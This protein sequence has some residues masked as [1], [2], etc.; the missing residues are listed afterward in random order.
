MRM[1]RRMAIAG[2][3]GELIYMGMDA[4]N[5]A[6]ATE[7]GYTYIL[8][9]NP[10]NATGKVTSIQMYVDSWQS[11]NTVTVATVYEVNTDTFTTRDWEYVYP[12][13]SGLNTLT[14]DLDV[15]E[16]DYLAIY[17]G[18]IKIDMVTSGNSGY[19]RTTKFKG[20]HNLSSTT[21]TYNSG[22]TISVCAMGK[23]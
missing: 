15:T 6:S 19:W 20:A 23:A 3:G 17:S 8:K 11:S 1:S 2:S 22:G 14:V 7:I 5:R 21:A 10:A 18:T 4:V 12:S 16:G 9:D 13:A